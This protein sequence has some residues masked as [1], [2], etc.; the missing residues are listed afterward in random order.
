MKLKIGEMAKLCNVSNR[1]LRYYEE[2]GLLIPSIVDDFTGYRYYGVKEIREL[3]FILRLKEQGFSLKDIQELFEE[4]MY[5][6][7]ISRLEYHFNQ[8]KKELETLNKRY[9]CLKLLIEQHENTESYTVFFP[10][11]NCLQLL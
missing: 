11:K 9:N 5:V 3:F 8:C 4:G 2:I 1:M 7:D 6:S 10:L